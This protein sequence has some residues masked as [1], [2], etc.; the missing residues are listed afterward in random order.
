MLTS[1]VSPAGKQ[2]CLLVFIYAGAC[3]EERTELSN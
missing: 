1:A 3:L 2:V